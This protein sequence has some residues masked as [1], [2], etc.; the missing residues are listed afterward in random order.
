MNPVASRWYL[1]TQRIDADLD[2]FVAVGMQ[3]FIGKPVP[4]AVW[5]ADNLLRE[6][7]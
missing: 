2:C 4:K 6:L 1:W 7:G 5:A 3:I